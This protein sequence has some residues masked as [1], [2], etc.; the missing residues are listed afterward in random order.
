METITLDFNVDGLPLC[1]SSSK[2]VWPILCSVINTS[3][4]LLIGAYEGYTKPKSAKEFLSQF[5]SELKLLTDEGLC[6]EEKVYIIK[7]RC[8]IMDAPARSFIIGSKGHTGY[9]S[10]IRCTQKG[11]MIQNRV[12]FPQMEDLEMRSNE[13]FRSRAQ[14]AHH[15]IR[16]CTIIEELEIDMIQQISLDYMHIV[17]LGV[18]RTLLNSWI[19]KKGEQYSLVSWKIEMLSNSLVNLNTC[20]PCEFNRKPRA[21]TE[22]DR[23]KATEFRQFL[24][25]TGP[26]ILKQILS[27]ERYHHFLELSIAIRILLDGKDSSANNEC[28]QN[29]LHNFI[30]NIPQLYDV[31]FL[32]CNFH[33]LLH[34]H[35][36]AKLYG[37][38]EGI[39]AFKYENHLQ[40]IKKSVKKASH[41]ASQLYNRQVEKSLILDSVHQTTNSI[42][43]FGKIVNG[44]FTSVKLVHFSLT[45]KKPN[46]FCLVDNNIIKISKIIK[47]KSMPF[48]E[49]H[50]IKNLKPYFQQPISSEKFNIYWT[51]QLE[52]GEARSFCFDLIKKKIICLEDSHAHFFIPFIH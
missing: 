46:N 7:V 25:Y 51:S 29:L 15:N 1:K 22:L 38:L 14:P 45:A 10:C 3:D 12:V 24:L 49:G 30:E 26:F 11:E 34:L 33:C 40:K 6:Y 36:D 50:I 21:L 13:S 31:S 19:K 4:V 20:I 43:S 8:F 52:L 39:S 2:Q 47:K 37:S 42:F 32:T 9:Y 48:F 23:F 17:C 41:V 5:V 27:P 18:T 16:S 28:A 44:S 35:E